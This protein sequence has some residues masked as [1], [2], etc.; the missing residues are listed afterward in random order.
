ML[1]CIDGFTNCSD[2]GSDSGR[3]L[4]MNNTDR[5][6]LMIGICLETLFDLGRIDSMTPTFCTR[7][8]NK[9]CFDS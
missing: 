9:L 2:I 3:G 8:T 1:C 7:H 5:F 4:I 6:N